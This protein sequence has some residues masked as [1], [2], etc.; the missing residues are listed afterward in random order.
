M[1]ASSLHHVDASFIRRCWWPERSC[2][3]SSACSDMRSLWENAEKVDHLPPPAECE[4]PKY[5]VSGG[6]AIRPQLGSSHIQSL[7]AAVAQRSSGA[8]RPAAMSVGFAEPTRLAAG[9]YHSL[10]LSNDREL[11][12]DGD[13]QSQVHGFGTKRNFLQATTTGVAPSGQAAEKLSLA[14]G[15]EGGDGTGGPGGLLARAS[16]FTAEPELLDLSLLSGDGGEV[17]AVSC[18][19]NHSAL[20]QKRPGEEGGQVWIWGL[21][22]GG[23]LGVER[24]K[25]KSDLDH[26]LQTSMCAAEAKAALLS[27]KSYV[28]QVTSGDGKWGLNV[29]LR[30]DFGTDRITSISCGTDYTLALTENGAIYAWGIGSYGNL[31]T[32]MICDQWTPALVHM[33]D[34]KCWQVAA[35]TKHSMALARTG[36]LY[37]WGHGG[38]G[39]LGHGPACEA[40]L[41]PTLLQIENEKGGASAPRFK[42]LA[43]GEAHSAAIDLIGQVWCWGAGSFGRC[44]HGEEDD[45]MYPRQVS[46]MIGKSCC[47][48]ALGVCHSLALTARG[49]IW[50]WGGYLYTGHGESD[51]IETARELDAE[52]LKGHAIIEIAAGRFHSMALSGTGDVFSWGS[53]SMGRLGLGQNISDRKVPEQISNLRGWVKETQTRGPCASQS[54]EDGLKPSS[55]ETPK[56]QKAQSLESIEVLACGGMHSAAVEKDGSCWLWGTGEY[57]QNASPEGQDFWKPVLLA[58]MDPLS[59]SKIKVL[60][61][62]LGLEHCLMISRNLELFAW[63]RNHHGQLG[64]GT[65]KDMSEPTFVAA[66]SKVSAVAAGEDHSAAITPGGELYTWGNAE[67]GKLGHG[68]SMIRSSMGFPKQVRIENRMKSVS[69]G[70]MHTAV[71]GSNGELFTCGAGWFGRLGHG[72]MDNQYS[73]KLIETVQPDL[74]TSVECPRFAHVSCGSFHTCALDERSMVWVFGRDY[75]VCEEDH[76]KSP[77][78]FK[79]IEEGAELLSVAAGS[80]HTLCITSQGSLWGWGDNSKGQLGLGKGSPDQVGP[81]LISCKGWGAGKP[82]LLAVTCGHAH[83][84]ALTDSGEMWAWGLQSGGRLA[85]KAPYEGKFCPMPLKVYPSWKLVEKPQEKAKA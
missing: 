66:L 35:G 64:L 10:V 68:S 78:L 15:A 75:T 42:F 1:V 6:S 62:G 54:W 14:D 55:F 71:I 56:G 81:T 72:D 45:N 85:L 84:L 52:N 7:L 67:C 59:G 22:N 8:S 58:A 50:S 57:G 4:N 69:C 24:P 44:G 31:G 32:G 36:G 30:V 77:L 17:V 63:G 40:A 20:L 61:I 46:S 2:G 27:D 33:P 29:P 11:A 26:L 12:T 18:G 48:V 19:G 28:Q 25:K 83:S 51:D 3:E 73:L 60:T 39:R 47:Q 49:T 79:K 38:H 21:G 65:T 37:S 80:N 53:G 13:R 74:G 43:V 70:A 16:G 9:F 41:K 82:E 23:R 34:V 76:I 5:L